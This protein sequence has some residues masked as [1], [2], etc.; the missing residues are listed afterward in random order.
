MILQ[1]EFFSFKKKLIEDN[2]QQYITQKQKLIYLLLQ[3][4]FICCSDNKTSLNYQTI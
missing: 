4:Q 3:R 2:G 1:T